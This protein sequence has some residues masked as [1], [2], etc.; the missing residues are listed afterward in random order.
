M[1]CHFMFY[2]IMLNDI[3]FISCYV[4]LYHIYIHYYLSNDVYIYIYMKIPDKSMVGRSSFP[5]S[6]GGNGSKH[7]RCNSHAFNQPL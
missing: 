3:I 2:H 1:L 5:P 4:T 7:F 6:L